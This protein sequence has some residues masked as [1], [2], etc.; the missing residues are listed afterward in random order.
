MHAC[1]CLCGRRLLRIHV[2]LET[3]F[4]ADAWKRARRLCVEHMW[5][6]C[7]RSREQCTPISRVCVC[8][9]PSDGGGVGVKGAKNVNRNK[10]ANVSCFFLLIIQSFNKF[11]YESHVQLFIFFYC[12]D[13]CCCWVSRFPLFV[14]SFLFF[15]LKLLQVDLILTQF[16]YCFYKFSYFVSYSRTSIRVFT[17]FKLHVVVVH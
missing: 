3:A 12:F 10:N 5:M 9:R 13:G 1:T 7:G 2:L 8:E 15:Y 16:Q 14:L 6:P 11:L 17:M 4:Q